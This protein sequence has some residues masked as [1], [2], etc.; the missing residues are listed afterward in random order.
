MVDFIFI[1]FLSHFYFYFIYLLI[2]NSELR[3]KILCTR[4]SINIMVVLDSDIFF[5][6]VYFF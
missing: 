2:L 3:V 1:L 6:L 5:S 4:N